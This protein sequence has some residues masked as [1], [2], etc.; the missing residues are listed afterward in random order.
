LQPS[1]IKAYLVALKF[2]HLL[3]G[4]TCDHLAN[5]PLLA[6]MLKGSTHLA[7]IN[8]ISSTR[9][10]VTFPMLLTIG[11]KIATSGWDPL[12]QQVLFAACTTAFFASTRMG[13]ILACEEKQ[14]DTASNLTW[15]DV[16]HTSAKSILIR[17]KQPKSGEKEGE[18]VDL[19]PFPGYHCCPVKALQLLAKLQREAGVYD[20]GRPVFRFA[21]GRYLT[22]QHF[23][24][25]LMSMLDGICTP[26]VNTISCHSF[27]AGIPSTLSMFPDLAS[28]DDIKG[29][30]RWK[31]DCY[32]RYTRLQLPQ[33][34]TIFSQIA[35][36]LHS[37]QTRPVHRRA[38][39]T[40]PPLPRPVFHY[41]PPTIKF[42]VFTSAL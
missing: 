22:Q 7:N 6:I 2:V 18:Y 19:F 32:T 16:L 34:A 33:R 12:S 29:W 30:G 28:S 40:P 8:P 9:R 41:T 42:L 38:L 11:H 17:L 31:S 15:G 13:E 21:S 35:S 23:N 36:A 1:S 24:K 5:D 10:V 26:G 3:K 4:F 20:V 27:R 39:L 14:F 37:T 25:V